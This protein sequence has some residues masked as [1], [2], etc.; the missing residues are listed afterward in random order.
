V[1]VSAR[2]GFGIDQLRSEPSAFL[3]SL[4]VDIGV[5]V[6]YTAGELLARIRERGTVELEYRA[7]DVRVHGR[8]APSLAGELGAAA[9]RWTDAIA[10]DATAR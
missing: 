9:V 3:A 8:I 6:P 5:A 7:R 1:P 4:C 10:E 2:S